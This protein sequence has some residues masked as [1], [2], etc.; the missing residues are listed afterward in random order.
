MTATLTH[1]SARARAARREVAR[2]STSHYV[3]LFA[4]LVALNLMGLVM[5]LSA[6]SVTSLHREGSAWFYFSRQLVGV[7]GGGVLFLATVRIDHHVWRRA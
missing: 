5:V 7:V 2:R 3:L 6:S 4:V 1:P